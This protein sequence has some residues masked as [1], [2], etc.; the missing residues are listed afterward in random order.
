MGGEKMLKE[1][2]LERQALREKVLSSLYDYYFNHNG[3]QFIITKDELKDAP[4]E[5]LVYDYLEQKGLIH[6]ERQ[7]NQKML[8][9]ITVHGIELFEQ[10]FL[11]E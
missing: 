3:V 4:E 5:R 10:K 6:V 1:E 7:G 2:I 8:I 11:T 9:R